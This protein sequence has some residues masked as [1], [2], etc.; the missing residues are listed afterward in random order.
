MRHAPASEQFS[1][2]IDSIRMSSQSSS[3]AER[4]R[5]VDLDGLQSGP[6]FCTAASPGLYACVA[7]EQKGRGGEGK[8]GEGKGREG[9]GGEGRGGER[10][11]G[12]ERMG[13]G[14]REREREDFVDIVPAENVMGSPFPHIGGTEALHQNPVLAAS[15]AFRY[16]SQILASTDLP[17]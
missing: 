16:A 17:R 3:A 12:G 2:G 4:N 7:H 6:E 13:E 14:E 1:R 8:G 11:R 10:E 15:W 9:R 5:T